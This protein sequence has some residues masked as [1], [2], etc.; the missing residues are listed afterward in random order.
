MGVTLNI[1]Q[2]EN[3][4]YIKAFDDFLDLAV[5]KFFSI[6]RRFKP[7]YRLT[8]DY[9]REMKALKIVK[10]M[11]SI[12]I[13]NRQKD[14]EKYKNT[15]SNSINKRL[16]Q[17]KKLTFLDLLLNETDFTEIE[18]NDQ[19]NTFMLGVNCY[20]HSLPFEINKFTF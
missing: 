13:K 17:K 7:Y 9:K 16:F 15:N 11:T 18:I 6:F 12:I 2:N 4:E 5:L 1:Q 8:P 10:D 20:F 14:I 3:K 19:V